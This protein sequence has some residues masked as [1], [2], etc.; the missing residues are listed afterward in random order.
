[1]TLE[2][3]QEGALHRHDQVRV[4]VEDDVL[5][6]FQDAADVSRG[7]AAGAASGPRRGTNWRRR[8]ATPWPA[9]PPGDDWYASATRR[10]RDEG[11]LIPLPRHPPGRRRG[12]PPLPPSPGCLRRPTYR[13]GG[14]RR[15]PRGGRPGRPTE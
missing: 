4:V 13:R 14:P 15:C 8:R 10:G 7:P 3:R 2:G 5:V 12:K 1:V 9:P 11:Y 6:R